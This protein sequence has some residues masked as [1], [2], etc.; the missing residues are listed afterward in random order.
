MCVGSGGGGG[1]GGGGAPSLVQ[2]ANPILVP[3][4]FYPKPSLKV[5][6]FACS[7]LGNAL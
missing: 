1:G 4:F 7:A 5:S 6:R 2:I 3:K